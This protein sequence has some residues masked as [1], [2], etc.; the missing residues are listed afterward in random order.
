MFEV[1]IIA[2]IAAVVLAAIVFVFCGYELWWKV[3]RLQRDVLFAIGA[4]VREPEHLADQALD[5]FNLVQRILHHA[6]PIFSAQLF[7]AAI[8]STNNVQIEANGVERVADFVRHLRRHRAHHREPLRLELG[9]FK[10]LAF[11]NFRLQGGRAALHGF[12]QVVV[13][14]LQG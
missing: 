5:A 14:F 10:P 2:W 4:G 7:P 1:P 12:L 11:L 9:D 6:V 8:S 13:R 3:R